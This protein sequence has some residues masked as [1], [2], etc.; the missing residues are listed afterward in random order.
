M[1]LAETR[2][3]IDAIHSGELRTAPT[4][5]DAIFGLH[6]VTRCPGVP[7]IVLNPREAWADKTAYDA[8]ATRLAAMFQQ[9]YEAVQ[10][11]KDLGAMDG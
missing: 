1:K 11:G 4:E 9:N 3:I 5:A 8:A 7:D 6:R 10:S 2:A